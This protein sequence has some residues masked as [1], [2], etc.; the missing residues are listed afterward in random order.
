MSNIRSINAVT[1]AVSDIARSISFYQSIGFRLEH[2]GAAFA[3]FRLGEQA[4]NLTTESGSGHGFWGRVIFYVDDVDVMHQ[5]VS[6]A[7]HEPETSPADATWGERYFH[8]ND[9]DG[10]Q[11]SFA[12]PLGT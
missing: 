4:L 1:L 3:T 8:L 2:G 11:L 12:K 7:G 9:L 5:T 10:H 6:D